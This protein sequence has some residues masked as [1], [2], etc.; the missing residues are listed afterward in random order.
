M[1][2]NKRALKNI[3][4]SM[5]IKPVAMALSMVYI[6]IVLGYLGDEKY[7]FWTV[8][9]S[10][11]SWINYFDVGIGK[12][13]RNKLTVV[14][15]SDENESKKIVSTAYIASSVISFVFFCAFLVLCIVL[16]LPKLL[17][18]ELQTEN[19]LLVILISVAFICIN[20]VVG[21]SKE[22]FYAVHKTYVVSIQAVGIQ[23]ANVIIVIAFS[24][25]TEAS[26]LLV[27]VMYGMT[28]FI[29]N[30]ILYRLIL[31]KMPYLKPDKRSY[32]K[33]IF[34]SMCSFGLLMFLQNICS[35]ILNTT[36]SLIITKL[37]GVEAVTPYNIV[38]SVFN[39]I[40]SIMYIIM[41]PLWSEYTDAYARNDFDWIKKTIKR[42]NVIIFVFSVGAII[43][44][45]IF[46]PLAEIWLGKKLDYPEYLVETMAVYIIL[47]MISNNYNCVL[48]GIGKIKEMSI[49]AG[50]QAILNIPISIFL[51]ENIGM[52]RTGILLGSVI[53]I[54][55]SAVVAPLLVY[56]KIGQKA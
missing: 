49:L 33:K 23:I 48:Q 41:T 44:T 4:I 22:I 25:L 2:K 35:L 43:L 27:A 13:L 47:L 40:M 45:F 34:K 1:N 15:E 26:V 32:D 14:Y 31:K 20:F 56:K 39:M 19:S 11:I 50:I 51:A 5:L 10:V 55:L 21:L 24:F 38:F 42:V 37:Y 16:D 9:L 12:G 52:G 28:M 29:G 17:G 54:A 6:P 30:F 46:E 53:M 7:G 36:D 3:G 18:L 8:L